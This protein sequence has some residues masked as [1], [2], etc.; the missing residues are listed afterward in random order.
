MAVEEANVFAMEMHE[1]LDVY[2]WDMDETLILL[3]SLLKQ[4]YAKAFNGLKD[5]K[6]GL[7]IGRKWEDLILQICDAYF[8]YEPVKFSSFFFLFC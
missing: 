6:K 8:F 4:T 3:D 5:A 1:K 7:E 2:I